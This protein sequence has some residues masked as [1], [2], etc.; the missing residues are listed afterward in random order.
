MVVPRTPVP[1]QPMMA[2]HQK[3]NM[4]EHLA[5]IQEI[6][7]G[8]AREDWEG[9]VRAAGRI[10]SSPQMQQMCEHMGA[11]AD[12]FTELALEFHSRA[13]GIGE[14]GRAREPAAVLRETAR[15]LEVCIRCHATYR[16]DVVDAETWQARTGHAH[17]GEL[18]LL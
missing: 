12:G 9:I 8:L 18:P 10:G 17:M 16:Q 4:Q 6:T 11:G 15:T 1:L 2:W 13:D 14:A 5:A 7:D 3:Q